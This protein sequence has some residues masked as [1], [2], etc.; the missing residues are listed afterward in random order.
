MEKFFE[1]M[2]SG[3]NPFLITL[4]AIFI[5][6]VITWFGTKTQSTKVKRRLFS[7]GVAIATFGFLIGFNSRAMEM[8][9]VEGHIRDG[10]PKLLPGRAVFLLMYGSFLAV[11]WYLKTYAQVKEREEEDPQLKKFLTETKLTF[12]LMIIIFIF[13]IITLFMQE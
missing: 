10:L 4:V 8:R 11:S 9:Y 6:A 2:Q 12:L 1:A 3:Y 5:A 7:I 13:A